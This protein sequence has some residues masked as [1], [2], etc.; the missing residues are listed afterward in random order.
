MKN[1]KFYIHDFSL[2]R[3]LQGSLANKDRGHQ[4]DLGDVKGQLARRADGEQKDHMALRGQKAT[5]LVCMFMLCVCKCVLR[6]RQ[7]ARQILH[8]SIA[9]NHNNTT[10]LNLCKMCVHV[11]MSVIKN[12]RKVVVGS[13]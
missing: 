2:C 1:V 5:A 12:K 6:N 3:E 11:N 13:D 7:K 8:G 9:N 4:W 10:F